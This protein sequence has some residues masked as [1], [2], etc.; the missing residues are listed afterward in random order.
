MRLLTIL[1]SHLEGDDSRQAM[2][3]VVVCSAGRF[4]THLLRTYVASCK[5]SRSDRI[6]DVLECQLVENNAQDPTYCMSWIRDDSCQGGQ[7]KE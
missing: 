1:F 3:E 5:E 7:G 4:V 2:A 6:R